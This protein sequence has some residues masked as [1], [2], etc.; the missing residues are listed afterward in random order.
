MTITQLSATMKLDHAY[1]RGDIAFI[2]ANPFLV[3]VRDRN[4]IQATEEG[5]LLVH[6]RNSWLSAPAT[7]AGH[8]SPVIPR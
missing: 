8:L 5:G 6:F 4:D 1:E 7:I 2:S 3:P